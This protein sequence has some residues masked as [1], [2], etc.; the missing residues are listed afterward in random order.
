M[1]FI[2]KKNPWTIPIKFSPY[3]LYR[4]NYNFNYGSIWFQIH[5]QIKILQTHFYTIKLHFHIF[6]KYF[7][8]L[9][10]VTFLFFLYMYHSS[11]RFVISH[12]KIILFNKS[13]NFIFFFLL[14]V[15]RAAFGISFSSTM[16][17]IKSCAS[18]EHKIH[19]PKEC[20]QL[21]HTILHETHTKVKHIQCTHVCY[22]LTKKSG[23]L[24]KLKTPKMQLIMI[25]K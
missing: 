8:V 3:Y 18:F 6:I 25:F 17:I 20:V 7:I 15:M 24:Y 2:I 1:E 14:T 23:F 9:L 4:F 10:H 5:I 12:L 19:S 22:F 16:R 21:K 13:R 11:L